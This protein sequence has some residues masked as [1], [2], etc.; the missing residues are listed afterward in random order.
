MPERADGG[1]TVIALAAGGEVALR[2]VTADDVPAIVALLADDPLGRLRDDTGTTQ[3]LLPYLT[4]FASI[5]ADPT[6]L[7]VVATDQGDVVATLQL[8]FI[9]G[10]SRQGAL[11]AQVEGVRVA[12][13]HRGTGLGSAVVGWAIDEASRRGCSLVQLTSDKDRVRAHRFYERLGFRA[14]HEG[15]K[16]LL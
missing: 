12:R 3:D 6:Q 10:L 11:R 15:F 5:D 16:L 7:L 9:R 8:S 1:L 14:S 2:R 4:A 13:S